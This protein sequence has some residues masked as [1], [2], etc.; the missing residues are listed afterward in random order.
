MTLPRPG[1]RV[2]IRLMDRLGEQVRTAEV[3]GTY[4]M[5]GGYVLRYTK[6]VVLR[7]SRLAGAGGEAWVGATGGYRCTVEIAE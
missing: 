2:V 5:G 1:S 3:V 6:A 4:R 7:A